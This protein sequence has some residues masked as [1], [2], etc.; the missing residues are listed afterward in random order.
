MSEY[1]MYVTFEDETQAQSICEDAVR[2]KLAACANIFPSHKS[3]Y[4]WEGKMQSANECAA[5]LKTTDKNLD[6]LKDE[7]VKRHSYDVPCV[8]VWPIEKGHA[9]FL[10]WINREVL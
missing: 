8:V 3:V 5:I 10:D 1:M 6:A 2:E 7:I 4:W 9:P